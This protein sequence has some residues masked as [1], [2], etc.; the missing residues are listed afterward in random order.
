MY[1]YVFKMQ[2]YTYI[3]FYEE[4]KNT[5]SNSYYLTVKSCTW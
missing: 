1:S 5:N 3:L 2:K 4:K